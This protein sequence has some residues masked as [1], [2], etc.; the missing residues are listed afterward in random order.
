MK[1]IAKPQPLG[2]RDRIINVKSDFLRLKKELIQKNKWDELQKLMKPNTPVSLWYAFSSVVLIFIVI[3][4]AYNI[5]FPVGSVVSI[6]GLLLY[7]TIGLLIV[8]RSIRALGNQCHDVS[9][10]NIF[11]AIKANIWFGKFFLF[12]SMFYSRIAYITEHSSHHTN[13]GTPGRDLERVEFKYSDVTSKKTIGGKF[14]ALYKPFLRDKEF[15][16]SS[17]F[18]DLF[19]CPRKEAVA[20]VLWWVVFLLGL[21]WIFGTAFSLFFFLL[22]DGK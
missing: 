13:L 5:I 22:L 19:S 16:I 12:P 9:H 18:G 15:L 14:W 4:G 11:S 20:I 10:N 8:A 17:A 7:T 6:V 1:I 3:Y 21:G 2:K